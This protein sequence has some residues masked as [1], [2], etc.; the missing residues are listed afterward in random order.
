MPTRIHSGKELPGR[1]CGNT[2][3]A[4]EI[5]LF[6]FMNS[7]STN[8][9]YRNNLGHAQNFVH[10]TIYGSCCYCLVTQSC[11]ILCICI[12]CS[13]PGFP[14]LY[15]LPELAQTH[16]HWVGDTIQLTCPLWSP[17]P[18]PSIFPNNR[19]IYNKSVFH[20]RWL[21]Y[22][23]F[24]ISSSNEYSMKPMTSFRISLQSKGLSRVFSNTRIQKH[25]FFDAQPSLWFNSHIH[26]RPLEKP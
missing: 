6:W 20:I 12:N 3:N 17:S 7:T 4:L 16:V 21:K 14:V 15:H 13:T 2:V 11:L 19:V 5:F 1:L 10:E 26:T 24:S 18:L 9:F 22:W 23:S 25:Q 8:L